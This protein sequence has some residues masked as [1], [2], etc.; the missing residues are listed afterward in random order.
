MQIVTTAKALRKIV[1]TWKNDD[2][3]VGLVAT[4]GN[5]HD[6]HLSLV[7]RARAGGA[8]VVASI[9]VN[10]LQFGPNED[11]DAYPRTPDADSSAL[12]D[13]GCDLLYMPAVAEMYPNGPALTR[14][15]VGELGAQLCGAH[16]SGHFD[17]MAT[18]VIKLLNQVQ[19]DFALFGQKDYQQLVIIRRVVADLDLRVEIEGVPTVR[20]ADGLAMSS[21]NRYLSPSERAVA[22]QLYRCLRSVAEALADGERDLTRLETEAVLRLERAGFRPDYVAVRAP[23]LGVPQS[24]ETCFVVMAA[25]RLGNARLI[26]NVL[27]EVQTGAWSGRNAVSSGELGPV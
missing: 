23:N 4:M 25:A 6:G 20:E 1:D 27:V 5:L 18:V 8:R 11:Y 19:P 2:A 12:A 7:G 13:A 17:G 26:D 9:F 3:R 21:R 16:R 22:P 14:I 15:S 24:G 10:P